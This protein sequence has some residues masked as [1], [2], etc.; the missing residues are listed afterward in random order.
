MALYKCFVI[1][2]YLLCSFVGVLFSS[3]GLAICCGLPRSFRIQFRLCFLTYIIWHH[4]ATLRFC[5]KLMTLS[6]ANPGGG[7]PGRGPPIG[8]QVIFFLHVKQII[9]YVCASSA[10]F[11]VFILR[12]KHSGQWPFIQYPLLRLLLLT[13][14]VTSVSY[15]THLSPCR[16]IFFLCLI[17][18]LCLF[19]TFVVSEMLLI[20]RQLKLSLHL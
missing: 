15:S 9:S 12:I 17:L 5:T 19:V 20:P 7:H 1:T 10:N 8:L 2:Y 11:Y 3:I 13:R 18:A 4:P 6:V 16:I 14:L